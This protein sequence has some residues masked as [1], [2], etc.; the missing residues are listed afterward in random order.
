M[1][2]LIPPAVPPTL[3]PQVFW[4][5]GEVLDFVRA[6]VNDMQFASTGDLF[7]NDKP[8]VPVLLNLAYDELL[9]MLEESGV[10][11]VNV[12][13]WFVTG[14]PAAGFAVAPGILPRP[15]TDSGTQCSLGYD[16]YFDGANVTRGPWQLPQ[17]LLEPM[18]IWE[19]NSNAG[20]DY[21]LMTQHLGG[22]PARLPSAYFG[23]WE[24]RQMR[25]WFPASTS[26]N[27]LRIRGVPSAA[28]LVVPAP[29]Q[30]GMQVPL[31]RCGP[32]L[33]YKVAAKYILP[34]SAAAAELLESMAKAQV[35]R[36]GNRSAKRA[37]QSSIRRPPYGGGRWRRR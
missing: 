5:V 33:A 26:M 11:S 15:V 4:A 27:D 21:M 1:P 17:D 3:A 35:D 20:Q 31:A 19:R 18:T 30:P 23:R 6:I 13:E 14:I 10:E 24:F 22:F 29:D 9:D 7:T 16:G 28:E 25:L 32:V 34:R 36:M 8:Y 37:Q 2:I 12:K